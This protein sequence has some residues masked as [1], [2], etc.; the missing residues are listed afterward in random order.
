[1]VRNFDKLSSI[2]KSEILSREISEAIAY[3]NADEE[4]RLLVMYKLFKKFSPDKEFLKGKVRNI[5]NDEKFVID[6]ISDIVENKLTLIIENKIYKLTEAYKEE[7]RQQVKNDII[8]S[9]DGD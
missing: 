2:E 9:I 4:V 3:I 1:M 5:L 6:L 7:I 8:S